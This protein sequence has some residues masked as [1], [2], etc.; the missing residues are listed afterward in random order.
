MMTMTFLMILKTKWVGLL[1]RNIKEIHKSRKRI[2]LWHS[3]GWT[4]PGSG[5]N[6]FRNHRSLKCKCSLCRYSR[7]F[8]KYEK[9][10]ER[11]PIKK[12]L[13]QIL[14]LS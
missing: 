4:F 12:D 5:I 7:F 2:K 13:R 6:Y 1:K 11:T 10:V 14:N 3:M 9:R 8:K